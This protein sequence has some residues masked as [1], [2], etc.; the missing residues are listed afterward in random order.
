MEYE[1][2]LTVGHVV[3]KPCQKVWTRMDARA[4]PYPHPP[5]RLIDSL[6]DSFNKWYKGK[7]LAPL[8]PMNIQYP[9]SK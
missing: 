6:L 1:G 2:E 3:L 4:I 7:L 9:Y 5:P 8:R